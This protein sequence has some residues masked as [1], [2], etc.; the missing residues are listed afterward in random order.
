MNFTAESWS[1]FGNEYGEVPFSS[2]SR[3]IIAEGATEPQTPEE[4]EVVS[5]RRT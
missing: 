5:H 1:V 3:R 2:L 4:Q